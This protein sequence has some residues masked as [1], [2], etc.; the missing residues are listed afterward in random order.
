MCTLESMNRNTP[1]SCNTYT[2]SEYKI[3]ITSLGYFKQIYNTARRLAFKKFQ[4]IGNIHTH[5]KNPFSPSIMI[6]N[7]K[8]PTALLEKYLFVCISFCPFFNIIF[9]L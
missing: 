6:Q 5:Q 1:P 2:F 9:D 3:D 7:N 8:K 4:M